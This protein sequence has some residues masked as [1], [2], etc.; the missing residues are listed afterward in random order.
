MKMNRFKNIF[1][2]LVLAGCMLASVPAFAAGKTIGV[3][4]T[5]SI[6]YYKEV[7]KSFMETMASEGFGP[8]RVEI[9]VQAPNPEAMSWTNS[10]R[11]LVAIG[12][13]IIVSYGA[14]A[15]LAVMHETSDI[16]IVFAGVYDPLST[17]ITGKNIHRGKFK[18]F[19]GN[20]DQEFK[21]H[22]Q[23]LDPGGHLQRR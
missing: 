19:C 1:S 4:L 20:I 9:V 21:E 15:T 12:S 8:A 13:D 18:G 22:N 5:G 23:I 10:A 11:K 2:M 3:I 16:P 6:P 7:H 17:G 14:P